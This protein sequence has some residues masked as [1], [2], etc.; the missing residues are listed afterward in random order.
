MRGPQLAQWLTELNFPMEKDSHMVFDLVKEFLQNAGQSQMILQV[1]F[2]LLVYCY[3]RYYTW[4]QCMQH[5]FPICPSQSLVLT[6]WNYTEVCYNTCLYWYMNHLFWKW[7][8]P[9][10][11]FFFLIYWLLPF[12]HSKNIFVY[13]CGFYIFVILI[14]CICYFIKFQGMLIKYYFCI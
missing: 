10:P 1:C 2:V 12:I 13:G 11:L 14:R 7:C 8:K 6:Y 4:V 9:H 5:G 3:W